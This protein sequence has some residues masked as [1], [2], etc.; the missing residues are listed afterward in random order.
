MSVNA[1]SFR[2][3]VGEGAADYCQHVRPFALPFSASHRCPAP[4]TDSPL[5]VCLQIYDVMGAGWNAPG[6]VSR[7]SRPM[8]CLPAELTVLSRSLIST[9]LP[10][11]VRQ[12]RRGL[13]REARDLL[14]IDV[15][16]RRTGHPLVTAD[17]PPSIALVAARLTF[18]SSL[19]SSLFCVPIAPAHPAAPTS[20]CSAVST[21]G[22]AVSTSASSSQSSQ[23][24]AASS[25]A[26]RSSAAPGPSASPTVPAQASASGVVGQT[27][28]ASGRTASAVA[29]ALGAAGVV[30]VIGGLMV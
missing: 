12:L 3:C 15:P 9:V 5:H 11:L 24:T 13:G 1:F 6:D 18:L 2:A 20:Q 8:R 22:L 28:G 14:G 19:L 25:A 4:S 21:I 23:Q 30:G 26:P 27:G 17:R 16:P 10:W 7:S 29:V